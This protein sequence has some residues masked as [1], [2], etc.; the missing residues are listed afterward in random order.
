MLHVCGVR[1]I[2]SI[3][4]RTVKSSLIENHYNLKKLKNRPFRCYETQRDNA[5]LPLPR[6][7]ATPAVVNA[8]YS[9]AK[10]QIS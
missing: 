1:T 4:N 9:A 6:W 3:A 2:I 8:F 7:S 5:H 10:N